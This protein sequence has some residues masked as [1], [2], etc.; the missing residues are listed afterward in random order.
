MCY[1]RFALLLVTVVVV[2]MSEVVVVTVVLLFITF[3][4][5]YSTWLFYHCDIIYDFV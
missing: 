2:V 1:S 3:A 5:H 4:Q